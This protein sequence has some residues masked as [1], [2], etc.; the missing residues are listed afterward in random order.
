MKKLFFNKIKIL[1]FL[2]IFSS[3]LFSCKTSE[4][5]TTEDQS[6]IVVIRELKTKQNENITSH[7]LLKEKEKETDNYHA[8]P[9]KVRRK[10]KLIKK[11]KII[12]KK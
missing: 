6:E 7:S 5:I 10:T 9:L 3:L 8:I 1:S 12:M 11:S 4:K 2:I